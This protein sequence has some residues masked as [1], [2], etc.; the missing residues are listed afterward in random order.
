MD[1]MEAIRKLALMPAQRL[2]SVA[3]AFKRKGRIAVGADADISVFDPVT[4]IDKSTYLQPAIPS[5]GFRYVLVNGVPVVDDG[6][7]KDSVHP[8]RGM[9]AAIGPSPRR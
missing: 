2:Q 4:V 9:R 1:L 7:L 5:L 8:G 3:P 6:V